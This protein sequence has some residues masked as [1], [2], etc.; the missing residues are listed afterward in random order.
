MNDNIMTQIQ[1]LQEMKNKC[2]ETCGYYGDIDTAIA[3]LQICD[4]YGLDV[5]ARFISDLRIHDIK[6]ND[7]LRDIIQR[8]SKENEVHVFQDEEKSKC[9]ICRTAI[10]NDSKY[11][12]N[13]GQR[14][15]FY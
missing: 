2:I 4:T 14:V 11:C 3:A 15:I 8:S 7:K 12:K 10:D 5:T 1:C 9:P 13:C 6:T